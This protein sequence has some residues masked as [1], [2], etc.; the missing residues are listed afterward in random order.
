MGE[1]TTN[2]GTATTETVTVVVQL[3]PA[4]P[5]AERITDL[6]ALFALVIVAA[7]AVWGMKQILN[8]FSINPDND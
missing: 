5:D 1:T 7:V 2:T 6:A 4:P 3:E 8:L